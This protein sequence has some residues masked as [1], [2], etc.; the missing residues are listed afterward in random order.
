MYEARCG[1]FNRTDYIPSG[2]S[3]EKRELRYNLPKGCHIQ[4][5]NSED[6]KVFKKAFR[7]SSYPTFFLRWSEV[8]VYKSKVVEV[9]VEYAF[10]TQ[11]QASRFL[12]DLLLGFRNHSHL[13]DIENC[14][15]ATLEDMCEYE[16]VNAQN[17]QLKEVSSILFYVEGYEEQE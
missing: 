13:E 12:G 17:F 1:M 4:V 15:L 11:V 10:Q 6:V 14:G 7:K 9:D 16:N 8:W 2:L 5:P 3:A